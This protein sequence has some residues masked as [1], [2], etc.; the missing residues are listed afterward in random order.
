L[1]AIQEHGLQV[2]SVDSSFLVRPAQ[3]TD[4]PQTVGSVD[5]VLLAVKGWQV[6]GAIETM[7]PLMGP[8]L[9]APRAP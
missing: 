7:R 4:D 1:H 2:D 9:A 8:D 5:A 6:P 3:A